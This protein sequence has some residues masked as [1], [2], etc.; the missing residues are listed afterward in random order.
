MC[1]CAVAVLCLC[2]VC[3]VSVLWP[4]IATATDCV[5]FHIAG[6]AVHGHAVH[7]QL[8]GSTVTD[9]SSAE[10]AAIVE[11]PESLAEHCGKATSSAFGPSRALFSAPQHA[12]PHPWAVI[13]CVTM[14]SRC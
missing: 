9:W 3:A 10:L 2:C 11:T 5:L 1:V 7:V 13:Y 4:F 6:D 12:A 8:L 14:L